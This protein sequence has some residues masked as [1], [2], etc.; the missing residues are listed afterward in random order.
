MVISPALPAILCSSVVRSGSN[1]PVAEVPSDAERMAV[2]I[3]GLVAF[4]THR[5]EPASAIL[6]T[7]GVWRC[8]TLP[9][10]DRVLNTLFSPGEVAD[11]DDFAFGRAELERVAGWIKGEVQYSLD[12]N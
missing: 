9:V 2:P 4:R 8:P 3:L 1:Q 12:L 10:L 6:D 7:N 5:G 11:R